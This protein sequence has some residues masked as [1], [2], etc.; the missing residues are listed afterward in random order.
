[1]IVKIVKMNKQF[2]KLLKNRASFTS[3]EAKTFG[4]SA[5]QLAYYVNIGILERISRGLYRNPQN[6]LQVP[7]PW[8]DLVATVKSIP[9]GVICLV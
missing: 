8:E 1:M 7:T 9:K 6:D 2:R 5:S 3:K 4:I